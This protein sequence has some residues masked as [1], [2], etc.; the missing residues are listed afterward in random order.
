MLHVVAITLI[1]PFTKAVPTPSDDDVHHESSALQVRKPAP[2]MST[3]CSAVVM[4]VPDSHVH[5]ALL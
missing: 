2:K 1:M 3:A 4:A 5:K